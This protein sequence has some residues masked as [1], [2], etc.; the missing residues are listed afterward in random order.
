MAD[1]ADVSYFETSAK[2]GENVDL[3]FRSVCYNLLSYG[4]PVTLPEKKFFMS[5]LTH[6]EEEKKKACLLQ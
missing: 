1:N 5:L 6:K 3:M 2:T 4:L